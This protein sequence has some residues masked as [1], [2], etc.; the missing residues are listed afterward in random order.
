MNFALTTVF[1]AGLDGLVDS[2]RSDWVGPAFIGLIMVLAVISLWKREWRGLFGLLALGV[3]VGL[4]VF[5]GDD[6]FGSKDATLTGIGNDAAK[7]INVIS[8][9]LNP[10]G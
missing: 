4:L 2:F 5:A 8:A 7:E 1:A 3:V 10:V 6:L 9:P